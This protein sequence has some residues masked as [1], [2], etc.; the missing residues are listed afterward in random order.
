MYKALKMFTYDSKTYQVG[1][2]IKDVP[3]R[4][5]SLGM[6]TFVDDN[7][8]VKTPKTPNKPLTEDVKQKGEVLT[9]DSSDVVVIKEESEN[10]EP[11]KDLKK[12]KKK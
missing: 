2:L 12:S 11:I 6:V 9:E 7:G 3:S 8:K 10:I 1:D 4:F 5:V